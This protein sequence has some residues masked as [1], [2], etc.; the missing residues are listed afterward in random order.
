M[1]ADR[2]KSYVFLV[3]GLLLV[4]G[5]LCWAWSTRAFVA[6]AH[7]APGRVVKFNAGSAHLQVEFAADGH[8]YSYP[9]N[10]LIAGYKVGDRVTVLYE[11]R[12]PQ[13]TAVIDGFG[14]IWGFAILMWLMGLVFTGSGWAMLRSKTPWQA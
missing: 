11:P 4:G 9:Q 10:G 8:S 5:T 12:Y 7:R 1:P 3:A 6:A 2:F 14:A 13:Q